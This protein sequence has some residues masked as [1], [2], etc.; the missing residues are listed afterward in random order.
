MSDSLGAD[1]RGR[2]EESVDQSSKKAREVSGDSNN[3]VIISGNIISSIN[4]SNNDSSGGGSEY[5]LEEAISSLNGSWKELLRDEFNK[6][7]FRNLASFIQKESNKSVIYPPHRDV[8]SAL[9]F[10]GDI[11]N[12]KVVIIGQDPYH[13]PGQAHGLAFSVQ[14]GQPKP[15]SLAN[16]F[17]EASNDVNIRNPTHGNLENWSRQGVLLLNTCLTVRKGEA[18]SHQKRGWETFTDAIIQKLRSKQNIVYL[19]WGKPAQSKCESID[20]KKNT[21]IASSHPSPLGAYKTDAPFMGSKCFSR[22]NSALE[23]YGLTPI[24]WNV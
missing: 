3:S 16:I 5:L 13:G 20:T 6:P 15:P 1:A 4:T 24:D 19:L 12:I 17:K 8:F 14:R 10:I 9:N 7:Y 2:D 23:K 11:N 22:C 21:I 18:N